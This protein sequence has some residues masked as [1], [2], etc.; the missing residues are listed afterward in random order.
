MVEEGCT[1]RFPQFGMDESYKL[2]ITT[3]EAIL[4][5]NQVFVFVFQIK[6]EIKI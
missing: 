3:G 5:A 1:D 2:N 6:I 4:R